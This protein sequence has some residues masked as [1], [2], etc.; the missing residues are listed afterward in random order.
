MVHTMGKASGGGVHDGLVSEAYHVG[1][2]GLVTSDSN[3]PIPRDIDRL[4]TKRIADV[5]FMLP[6]SAVGGQDRPAMGT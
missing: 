1:I 4:T 5:S 2:S 6:R 3:I